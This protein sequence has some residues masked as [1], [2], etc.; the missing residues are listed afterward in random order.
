[1]VTDLLGEKQIT[2]HKNY[3]IFLADIT[4]H[5]RD[6]LAFI[7]ILSKKGQNLMTNKHERF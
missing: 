1:M 3:N 6:N 2:V 4:M 7:L 5:D